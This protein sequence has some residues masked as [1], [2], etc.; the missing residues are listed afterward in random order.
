MYIYNIYIY[1]YTSIY[2]IISRLY[3]MTLHI[4][5]FTYAYIYIYIYVYICIYLYMYMYV[6]IYLFKKI[7]TIMTIYN[8]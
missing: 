1:I 7:M 2:N 6:F 4:F 3:K 5:V 8:C